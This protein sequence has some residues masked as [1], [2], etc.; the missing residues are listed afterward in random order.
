MCIRDR[1]LPIAA[2]RA[3]PSII[4]LEGWK[5]E[6]NTYP[7]FDKSN[8]NKINETDSAIKFLRLSYPELDKDILALL[9][10]D[11]SIVVIVSTDHINGVCLLYTSRCV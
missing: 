3:I 6:E 10:N 4:D 2:P 5:G 11:K 1:D 9:K 7:L 8:W